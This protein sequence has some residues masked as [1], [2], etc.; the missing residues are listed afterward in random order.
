ML[1]HLFNTMFIKKH[2]EFLQTIWYLVGN[3]LVLYRFPTLIILDFS[4]FST[5]DLKFHINLGQ[6]PKK[7]LN[8]FID[9]SFKSATIRSTFSLL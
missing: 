7:L 3:F 9:L 6:G 2:R 5:L 8:G 1:P 4:T